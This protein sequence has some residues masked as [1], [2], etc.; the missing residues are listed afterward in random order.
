MDSQKK[1]RHPV[2]AESPPERKRDRSPA[3]ADMVAETQMDLTADEEPQVPKATCELEELLQTGWSRRECGGQGDCGYLVV[4]QGFHF[5]N[6]GE[7]LDTEAAQRSASNLRAN[8]FQHIS[9]LQHVGRYREAFA[10]DPA[11]GVKFQSW[12]QRVATAG[13]KRSWIDG[14]QIQALPEKWD[15][16]SSS[17]AVMSKKMEQ[18]YGNDTLTHLNFPKVLHVKPLALSQLP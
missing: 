9:Q 18:R 10:S 2:R 4:A 13:Q 16:C 11:S 7:V 8:V 15:R 14:M 3:N 12:D 6:H 17:G 5:N 1:S